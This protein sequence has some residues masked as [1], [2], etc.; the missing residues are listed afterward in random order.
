MTRLTINNPGTLALVQDAGRPGLAHIGVGRSGVMDRSA[1]ALAN[2]LV[3]NTSDAASLELLLGGFSATTDGPLWFAVTGA[4]GDITLDGRRVEP[5]TATLARAGATLTIHPA[6]AGVRYYLAVRGGIAVAPV[7]GS[8]S[9]DT[10]A[11]LGPAPLAA[12]DVIP[13]G[14][15]P[16]IPIPSVD[17]VPIGPPAGAVVLSIRPGPRFG[18]YDRASWRALFSTRWTASAQ[19][20]RTGIRLENSDGVALNR[21][22]PDALPSEGMIPG[23]I[24]VSPDGSPTILAVDSPVTGGFPV[25]AVVT[26]A[27]LD[28]LGQLRPG[29]PVRFLL[30]TGH[31]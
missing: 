15:T 6:A 29:T 2:R 9:R 1:H 17:L 20:D 13:V 25:I 16:P 7:L 26:D 28:A 27:S 23:A 8:R 31:A 24:Q 3:G 19:S 10:L 30:A 18:W 4:W 5:H 22:G 14:P 21:V 11:A 12:G